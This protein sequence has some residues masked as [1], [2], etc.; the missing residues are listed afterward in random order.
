MWS[1]QRTRRAS[2][3]C[4]WVGCC[5]VARCVGG[6][7][8]GRVPWAPPPLEPSPG[9][10]GA[11]DR[12]A[13]Q[14]R[15]LLRRRRNRPDTRHRI[16][17][18]GPA[19]SQ[20]SCPAPPPRSR[21]RLADLAGPSGSHVRVARPESERSRRVRSAPPPGPA[22]PRETPGL[23]RGPARLV[24][25]AREWTSDG[26]LAQAGPARP[27]A[28]PGVGSCGMRSSAVCCPSPRAP[29]SGPSNRTPHPL[30]GTCNS[31][32]AR[33]VGPHRGRSRAA[34]RTDGELTP[35]GASGVCID[36][37]RASCSTRLGATAPT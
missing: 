4:T 24:S 10:V 20:R 14:T 30:G 15:S 22:R 23:A 25:P 3:S 7:A 28:R 35:Q 18:T 5:G 34:R 2:R 19:R 8:S 27:R 29:G 13:R 16:P 21:F 11:P 31:P 36:G 1:V 12:L 17:D 32:P 26:I 6:A 33:A 9:P 37:D